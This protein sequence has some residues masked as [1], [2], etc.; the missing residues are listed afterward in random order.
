VNIALWA[1]I[2]ILIFFGARLAIEVALYPETRDFATGD[3]ALNKK[4][5]LE[6][7]S[8]DDFQYISGG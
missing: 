5:T 7:L 1:A 4:P 2:I 8:A 6:D 3:P